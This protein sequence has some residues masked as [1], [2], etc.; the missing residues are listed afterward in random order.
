M[1]PCDSPL[2]LFLAMF[3]TRT[4]LAVVRFMKCF[5]GWVV[6]ARLGDEV[7]VVVLGEDVNNSGCC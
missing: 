1:I 7:P 4:R 6:V 3:L 2:T 5:W